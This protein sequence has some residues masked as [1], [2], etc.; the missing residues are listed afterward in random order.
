[1]GNAKILIVEDDPQMRQGLSDM[2]SEEGY[3]V[4]SVDSG[5]EAIKKVKDNGF[6]IVVT[7]I[8]MPG[9]D[10]M[11]VLKEVKR[12]EPQVHVIMITAFATIENAVDAM[13][14]GASDYITKP[15]KIAEVEVAIKRVLEETKFRKMIKEKFSY[16]TDASL[17]T[18]FTIKALSNPIRR[19]VIELLDK[20]GRA[21]FTDI[22]KDLDIEDAT[23]LSFH[24]RILRNAGLLEQDEEKA[25]LPTTK[26]IRAAKVLRQLEWG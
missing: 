19:G 6:D 16:P 15:F 9:I 14:N 3:K 10:G 7:D 11:E 1:M 8:V 25:Y 2:L 22:K 24:L 21:R 12:I 17:G 5:R 18:D 4:L 23:K 13:K 26:G 20:Y